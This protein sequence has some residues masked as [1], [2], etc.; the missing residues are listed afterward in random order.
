MAAHLLLVVFYTALVSIL[1]SQAQSEYDCLCNVIQMLNNSGNNELELLD[2]V[3]LLEQQMYNIFHRGSS[4]CKCGWIREKS[5]CYFFGKLETV[6]WVDAVRICQEKGAHL[7]RVDSLQEHNFIKAQLVKLGPNYGQH[8]WTDGNDLKT[9]GIWVWGNSTDRI[10]LTYWDFR[11]PDDNMGEDCL[12]YS[13]IY[14]Y[15]W[16][17]L[18]CNWRAAY[19]CEI[20]DPTTPVNGN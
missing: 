6:I 16:N 2:R 12:E 15:Q 13:A 10:T 20:E 1:T 9:E 19:I 18:P 3:Q 5:S 17:D 7:V 4:V 11:Q 8:F 14:N